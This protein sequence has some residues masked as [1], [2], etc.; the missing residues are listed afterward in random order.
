MRQ[1]R[2]ERTHI[3]RMDILFLFG[4]AFWY[5][6]S[7]DVDVHNRFDALVCVRVCLRETVVAT[8]FYWT[9]F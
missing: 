1:Q 6:V 8:T 2:R 3:G 4:F 5:Y 7:I 9:P